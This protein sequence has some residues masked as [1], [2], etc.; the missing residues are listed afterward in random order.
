MPYLPLDQAEW[1]TAGF[2]ASTTYCTGG[3]AGS[4][5][6]VR[7]A[8]PDSLIG[9]PEYECLFVVNK[10]NATFAG[11]RVWVSQVPTDG[12]SG[13]AAADE[14]LAVGVDP[15]ATATFTIATS[16]TRAVF[17]PALP[18]PNP[19]AGSPPWVP[20]FQRKHMA[21]VGVTFSVPTTMATGVLVGTLGPYQMRA[22]WLRR[23]ITVPAVPRNMVSARVCVAYQTPDVPPAPAPAPGTG[24]NVAANSMYLGS[25]V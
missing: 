10:A 1:Y 2:T 15:T 13:L 8:L 20:P 6:F 22:V 21:P 17:P 3:L 25:V 24:F 11:V 7:Y 4:G 19:P 18:S 16:P 14:E 5:L 23:T 9:R 12:T